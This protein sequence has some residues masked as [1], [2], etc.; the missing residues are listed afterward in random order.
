MTSFFRRGLIGHTALVVA[1]GIGAYAGGLPAVFGALPRLDLV[2][3]LILIGGVAFFLDGALRHRAIFRGRGS[4]GGAI[5]IALAGAEEWAQRFSP[6]RSSTFS[7]FAADVV[8][9][10]VFVWLAR[11]IGRSAQ[12]ADA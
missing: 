9:V 2:M 10:L 12:R 6:R 3:H 4:L 8:G 7:D 1:I 11:R 5:V